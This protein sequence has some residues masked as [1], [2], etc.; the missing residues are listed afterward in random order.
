MEKLK[1]RG[2]LV[3]MVLSAALIALVLSGC[4]LIPKPVVN[5]TAPTSANVSAYPV[6]T[7][8]TFKWI[9][10]QS[11]LKYTLTLNAS[12]ATPVTLLN[13]GTV[14]SLTTSIA[15]PGVYTATV[16]AKNNSG[17]VGQTTTTFSV[18]S[19]EILTATPVYA[20]SDVNVAWKSLDGQ[21]HTYQYT[22]GATWYT[23]TATSVT[24]PNLSDGN[25][26]FQ[27]KMENSYVPAASYKFQVLTAGP[28]LELT[29]SDRTEGSVMGI[30]GSHPQGRYAY[31]SWAADQKLGALQVKFYKFDPSG[32]GKSYGLDINA[33]NDTWEVL[34][35]GQAPAAYVIDPSNP[36]ILVSEDNV[37]DITVSDANGNKLHVPAMNYGTVYGFRF[38]PV[39]WLGTVSASHYWA[40]VTLSERYSDSNTPEM[41][42]SYD[43]A[44][45]APG[46]SFTTSVVMPNVTAYSSGTHEI[47]NDNVD[48]TDIT[49]NDGL[50]YTQFSLILAPGLQIDNVTFP[51]MET[52]KVNLSS[53]TYDATN[54]VL[55]VYRGFADPTTGETVAT[56]ATDVAVN[57][58]CTVPAS[59]TA[60]ITGLQLLYVG[61]FGS[62]G[63]ANYNPV[64][65]DNS[66]KNIDGIVTVNANT[67]VVVSA[68][69]K[70]SM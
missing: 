13:D 42:V 21:A 63:Y 49:S 58:Q 68:A 46:S 31:V 24:L 52:G 59:S 40:L 8:I 15:T 19:L 67:G 38:V 12:G 10:N 60:S 17:G 27:V 33:A 35:Y 22:I 48:H 30:V 54:G 23:T 45:V 11:N 51:N 53:Y 7:P 9:G 20:D 66:L 34:P 1:L 56:S 37:S 62:E 55:T 18:S 36:G 3:M 47:V 16:S 50:M 5:F 29:V 64:F 28:S 61:Y 26:T 4:F 14:N 32:T 2:K 41:Y 44:S 25:Y 43:K 65:K 69:G 39:N 6:N 70:A 57:V